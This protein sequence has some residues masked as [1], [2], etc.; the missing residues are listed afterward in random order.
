MEE[1]RNREKGVG[2]IMRSAAQRVQ[3]SISLG[4]KSILRAASLFA[5]ICTASVPARAAP[6]MD[7]LESIWPTRQWQTSSPGEQGM[8]S[9]EL[10]DLVAFGAE[11]ILARP[12]TTLTC[13][14]DS[15]LVVR[16]GK[17]VLEAYYA[18][19]SAGILHTANSVTKAVVST[20][21]AIASNDGLLDSLNHRV[22]DFFDRH[23]IAKVDSRKEAITVQNL[24]DMTSGLDWSEPLAEPRPQ[25]M[26]E[27]GRSSNW[28]KFILDRPMSSAPGD[29]FNYNSGNPHL[30]SAILTKLAGMSTL[31]YAKAKLFGPLGINDVYWRRDPQGNFTGGFGLWLQP[32][33]MAKIGYLYLRNGKWEGKQLLPTTWIDKVN[34]AT[35]DMHQV[36]LKYSNLFWV[37]PD[38]HVYMAVGFNGQ[39][40]M[41]FPD[42]DIVVVTTA[43]ARLPLAKLANYISSSV[44]S[45]TA[46][47]PDQ[48]SAKLLANEMLD[49]STEKP[50]EVGPQ[51]KLASSISG[52]I[53]KF[54]PNDLK[55]KSV[56]LVLTDPH[57]HY[58]VEAYA[59]DSD[60]TKL[61]QR[62]AGPIGLDGL[63]RKGAPTE[64][65]VSAVKGSWQ[66]ENTFVIDRLLLGQ[67]RPAE[68]WT[69]KFDGEKLS[70]SAETENGS[71]ISA[72]SKTGG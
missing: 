65:G 6:A 24:L 71:E 12:G 43:R 9:K 51:S 3:R 11:R 47:P 62:L 18:P 7:A 44:K 27:M 14:L 54:A 13:R 48:A 10:A 29:T 15:L 20:L 69:L 28:V 70:F 35:I 56:S 49:A 37:L 53:Y 38:K 31:E 66:D 30:L 46:L 67:G 2:R 55:V 23:S 59:N 40:I 21:V 1:F 32:R 39:V 5:F 57:P 4:N 8:D 34:H 60:R 68:R 52:K 19:Y 64:D 17:I 61:D 36:G 33:D 72:D 42:L 45:D 22:I 26:I 16:H 25:S 50:T 58:D 41:V 63:Y